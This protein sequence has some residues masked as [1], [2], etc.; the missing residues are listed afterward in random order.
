MVL[1]K[2]LAE[3]DNSKNQ[4]YLGG[5][6][7]ALN[8][9]PVDSIQADESTLAGSKRE[10]AKASMK[11]NWLTPTGLSEAPFAQL[12]LYPKYP[13]VR[14]SGILRATTGAPN[15]L[16]A[17]RIAGRLLFLGPTRDGRVLAHVVPPGSP[18]ANEFDSRAYSEQSGVFI[19]IELTVPSNNARDLLLSELRRVNRLGIVPGQRML[20]DG[21][22]VSNTARNAGGTTLEAILGIAGNSRSE[23][24]LFG[25]ELKQYGTTGPPKYSATSPLTLMTPEPTGGFYKSEGIEKFLLEFGYPDKRGIPGRINFGGTYSTDR[26]FHQ[27]TNLRLTLTQP[28]GGDP[29]VSLEG[30]LQMI[31]PSGVVA[32]EWGL[33]ELLTHWNRKHAQA[34][35]VP[36]TKSTIPYGFSYGPTVLLCEG[37][38][39]LLFV[40][41]VDSGKIFLDPAH[42]RTTTES[43]SQIKRRNQ[44]RIKFADVPILYRSVERVS[45]SEPSD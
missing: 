25:W 27:D 31:D 12:I 36:S 1:V 5:D 24:D 35:Y 10:R 23:P 3:N 43:R 34:A 44:F 29:G 38:D 13:E 2:R 21:S 41:A 26:G 37:T 4:I 19:K 15:K 6:F 42:K 40:R 17:S 14:L 28:E 22:I 30:S 39:F 18:I 8:L 33:K 11:F 45:L 9:L 7:E 16:V 32:A 20:T